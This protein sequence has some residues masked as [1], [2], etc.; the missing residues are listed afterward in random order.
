M[1]SKVDYYSVFVFNVYTMVEGTTILFGPL[2]SF[3]RLDHS[4]KSPTTQNLLCISFH[5]GM[6]GKIAWFCSGH[7]TL[8]L[9]F[10]LINA[11]NMFHT[12]LTTIK[13]FFI[14]VHIAAPS[15]IVPNPLSK[16]WTKWK[17]NH[18]IC[19]KKTCCYPNFLKA[20]FFQLLFWATS[21]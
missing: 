12:G 11:G 14:D 17:K 20:K 6:L 3:L 1:F 9:H 10:L 21:F 4:S 8:Y 15:T 19:H 7:K 5:D 13:V 2:W 18:H 16:K